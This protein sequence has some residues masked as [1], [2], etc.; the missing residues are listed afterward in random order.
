MIS[1]WQ[2]KT[3]YYDDKY[4]QGNWWYCNATEHSEIPALLQ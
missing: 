4:D 3:A 1:F 2:Q